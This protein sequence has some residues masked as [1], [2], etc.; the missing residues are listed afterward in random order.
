MSNSEKYLLIHYAPFYNN[1]S[2]AGGS[3]SAKKKISFLSLQEES[4][5]HTGAQLLPTCWI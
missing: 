3:D 2:G 1:V 5:K 4:E